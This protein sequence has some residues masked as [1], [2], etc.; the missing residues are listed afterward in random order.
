MS[1]EDSVGNKSDKTATVIPLST[2]RELANANLTVDD[3]CSLCGR[4]NAPNAKYCEACNAQF[5]LDAYS[6]KTI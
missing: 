6:Q 1:T 5:V 4:E 3:T 2:R